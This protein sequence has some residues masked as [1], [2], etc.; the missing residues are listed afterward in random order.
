MWRRK[1]LTNTNKTQKRDESSQSWED[2]T[3]KHNR[4]RNQNQKQ[5]ET[6]DQEGRRQTE[7]EFLLQRLQQAQLLVFQKI[8]LFTDTADLTPPP[9][10]ANVNTP[11]GSPRLATG[12]AGV[13]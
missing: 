10:Q 2:G 11:A 4:R 3:Q 6:G 5:I 13:F 12:N 7:A 8:P 9:Q 1:H